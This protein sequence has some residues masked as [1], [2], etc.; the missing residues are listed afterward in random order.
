MKEAIFSFLIILISSLPLII[1]L[2]VLH[3]RGISSIWFF[4]CTIAGFFSVAIVLLLN[5]FFP[6][7]SISERNNIF[8]ILIRAAFT[9]EL[10]RFIVLMPLLAI[11]L[12]K[13]GGRSAVVDP[14]YDNSAWGGIAG[15]ITG[16]GFAAAESIFYEILTP[17]AALL[18]AFSAAPLHGA[19]GARVGTACIYFRSRPMYAL[20][21]F[22]SAAVIHGMYNL[23]LISYH[24]PSVLALMLAIAA[25]GSQMITL[26]KSY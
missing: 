1:A 25:M 26:K 13:R 10:S 7:L 18:R 9:E 19:C 11:A 2:I 12:Q 15:L 16:L 3:K 6:V 21:L 17:G 8:N 4:V 14:S 5:N 24:L 22:L 23:F 20:Y